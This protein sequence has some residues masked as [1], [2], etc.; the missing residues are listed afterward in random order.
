VLGVD[1]VIDLDD[2]AL[3]IERRRDRWSRAVYRWGR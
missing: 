2:A 1:R 3:E